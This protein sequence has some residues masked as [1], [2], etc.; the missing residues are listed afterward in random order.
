MI[1]DRISMRAVILRDG[2]ML[3]VKLRPTDDWYC[4]PGGKMEGDERSFQTVQR[5]IEEEL[6]VKLAVQGIL[7]SNE[8]VNN[9]GERAFE[10]F[11]LMQD[12]PTIDYAQ[13]A[14]TAS[15]GFELADIRWVSLDNPEVVVYPK[16]MM[17]YVIKHRDLP[18][19]PSLGGGK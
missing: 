9:R 2:N 7:A 13:T 1:Y 15:H 4:F 12:D 14:K 18:I 8:F 17:E 19:V 5:E 10:L 16:A 3:V 6:G 11:F